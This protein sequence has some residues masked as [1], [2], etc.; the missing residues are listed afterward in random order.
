MFFLSAFPF[1]LTYTDKIVSS[2]LLMMSNL[3]Q[4]SPHFSTKQCQIWGLK[5]I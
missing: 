4:M 5:S 3:N 1:V 2:E